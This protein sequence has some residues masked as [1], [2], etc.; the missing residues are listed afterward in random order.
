MKLSYVIILL[1]VHVAWNQCLCAYSG[2]SEAARDVKVEAVVKSGEA[3]HSAT[4]VKEVRSAYDTQVKPSTNSKDNSDASRENAEN[5]NLV[6]D[7]DSSDTVIYEPNELEDTS[8]AAELLARG[9]VLLKCSAVAT[10]I[11]NQLSP[12]GIILRVSRLRNTGELD[13]LQFLTILVSACVWMLYGLLK[14]DTAIALTNSTALILGGYYVSTY[15]SHCKNRYY[16]GYL[17]MYYKLASI[18][19]VGL[20]LFIISVGSSFAMAYIGIVGAMMS[21][22]AYAAPLAAIRIVIRDKS[23]ATMPAEVCIGNFICAALWVAYGSAIR[24]KYIFTPN[25]FGVLVG[26]LQIGILII[27]PPAYVKGMGNPVKYL[28]NSKGTAKRTSYGSDSIDTK[29]SNISGS[30]DGSTLADNLSDTD[31]FSSSQATHEHVI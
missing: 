15:H 22:I 6:A 11:L 5:R 4:D 12:M 27:Y 16:K 30:L 3:E 10:S 18:L 14:P 2:G 21:T 1:W 31:T 7:S 19:L 24:D 23:S 9:L 20:S 13:G 26:S 25:M 8:A 17:E 29:R 28:F